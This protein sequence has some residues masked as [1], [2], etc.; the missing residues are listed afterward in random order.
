EAAGT[1]RRRRGRPR[2]RIRR[3]RHRTLK[4]HVIRNFRDR[5]P[6]D[7]LIAQRLACRKRAISIGPAHTPGIPRPRPGR[8][9][10][11]RLQPMRKAGTTGAFACFL[12]SDNCRGEGVMTTQA[13]KGPRGWTRDDARLIEEVSARLM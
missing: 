8:S 5:S 12:L 10:T 6:V 9:P 4:R 11:W 13:G 2:P 3:A 7:R 1:G